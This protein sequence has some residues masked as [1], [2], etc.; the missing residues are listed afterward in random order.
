MTE[1]AAG[2]VRFLV[3]LGI[4]ESALRLD[5]RALTTARQLPV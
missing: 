4:P 3:D 5:E 1:A 2:G